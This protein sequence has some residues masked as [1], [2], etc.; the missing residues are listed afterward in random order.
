MPWIF[1][2]SMPFSAAIFCAAGM[3]AAAVLGFSAAAGFFFSGE[4]GV[5][6]AA[7]LLFG[8]ASSLS[9]YLQVY[10]TSVSNLFEALPYALTLVAVA[11]VIGRSIPPAAISKPYV[12]Q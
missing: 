1:D 3:T 5:A 4:A 8:F 10:S 11:G 12:K 9:D 2:V 7:C 6:A